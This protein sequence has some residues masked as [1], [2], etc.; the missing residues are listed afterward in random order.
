MAAMVAAMKFSFMRKKQLHRLSDVKMVIG[1][2]WGTCNTSY[3]PLDELSGNR[4]TFLALTD[5][6]EFYGTKAHIQQ[7]KELKYVLRVYVFLLCHRLRICLYS[8]FQGA[9][10]LTKIRTKRFLLTSKPFKEGIEDICCQILAP[11]PNCWQYSS[12]LIKIPGL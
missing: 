1:C 4:D 8:D 11:L 10:F 12:M 6:K 2:V 5:K 3:Q 7:R 9:K